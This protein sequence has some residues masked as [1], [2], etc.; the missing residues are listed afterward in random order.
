MANFK[1]KDI[2]ETSAIKVYGIKREDKKLKGI[3]MGE[4]MIKWDTRKTLKHILN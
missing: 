4:E 3:M 2:E 1:F